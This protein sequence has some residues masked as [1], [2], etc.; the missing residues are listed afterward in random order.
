MNIFSSNFKREENYAHLRS[1]N[2]NQAKNYVKL[3]KDYAFA[4]QIFKL[5]KQISFLPR[6]YNL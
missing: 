1:T 6:T 5:K 2:I 4:G 3:R